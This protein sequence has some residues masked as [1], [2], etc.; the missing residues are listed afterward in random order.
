MITVIIPPITKV[1]SKPCTLRDPS[2]GERGQ[3]A[4]QV[5][6]ISGCSAVERTKRITACGKREFVVS[7]DS[8]NRNKRR[9]VKEIMRKESA[10]PSTK[11]CDARFYRE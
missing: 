4:C 5:Q 6:F 3:E 1:H 2:G 8:G 10:K 11:Y 9:E 7:N